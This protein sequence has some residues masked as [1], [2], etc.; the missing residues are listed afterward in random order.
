MTV[1]ELERVICI[2]INY[3]I[4]GGTVIRKDTVFRVRKMWVQTLVL[5]LVA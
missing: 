4:L 3:S 5:P 2:T 1:S